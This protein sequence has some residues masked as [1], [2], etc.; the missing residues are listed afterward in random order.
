M[1]KYLPEERLADV[2]DSLVAYGAPLV[3]RRPNKRMLLEEA[4]ARG[5]LLAKDN[6]TVLSVFPVL[7]AKVADALDPPALQRASQSAGVESEMGML[8]ALTGQL[9]GNDHLTK[10]A[11]KFP[12]RQGQGRKFF[13]N[14]DE[15]SPRLQL[16]AQERTPAV[17]RQW[18]FLMNASQADFAERLRKFA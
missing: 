11:G 16:L 5:V 13:L 8:L 7:L 6:A 9:A 2:W 18:G 3:G 12:K 4:L 14:S 10:L 1:N 17:V 15:S